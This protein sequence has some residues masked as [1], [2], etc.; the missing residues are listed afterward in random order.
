MHPI[1][2]MVAKFIRSLRPDWIG[3]ELRPEHM[4]RIRRRCNEYPVGPAQPA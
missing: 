1:S 3:V 4:K 2:V